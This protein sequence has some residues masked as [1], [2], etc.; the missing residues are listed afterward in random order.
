MI[1]EQIT[2]I[3][4]SAKRNIPDILAIEGVMTSISSALRS[5][6]AVAR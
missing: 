5:T 6:V 2:V 1:C 4:V 3:A